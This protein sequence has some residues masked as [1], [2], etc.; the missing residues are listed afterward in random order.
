[1][2]V[3][4]LGG[5]R[6]A[7]GL[8]AVAQRRVVQA[9]LAGPREGRTPGEAR[10]GRDQRVERLAQV[11]HRRIIAPG[12]ERPRCPG[13]ALP[14]VLVAGDEAVAVVVVALER[15]RSALPLAPAERAVA[16]AVHA[17]EPLL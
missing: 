13:K 10:G 7:G 6:D 14:E 1:E 3:L 16:V 2:L 5:E 12:P 17:V 8:L 15:P 9:D 4:L 11:D